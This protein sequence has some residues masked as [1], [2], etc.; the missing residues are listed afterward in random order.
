[1]LTFASTGKREIICERR[2]LQLIKQQAVYIA[3]GF[4]VVP[5]LLPYLSAF[6]SHFF[7]LQM[8]KRI[9]LYWK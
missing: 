6:R 7:I 8:L 4:P 3:K 9:P 5:S 2:G 1:M